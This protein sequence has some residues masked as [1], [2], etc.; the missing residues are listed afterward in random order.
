NFQ[1]M[2]WTDHLGALQQAYAELYES[3]HSLSQQR[4]AVILLT[5]GRPEMPSLTAPGA[6]AA[7]IAELRE[8]VERFARRDCPIF[9]I[10][11]TPDA[12]AADPDVQ[13]FYRNLWQEIAANTPPAAYYELHT[14]AD[15]PQVYHDIIVQLLG[16][17]PTRPIVQLQ[18]NHTLTTTIPVEAGLS[19]VVLAI[20]KHDPAI[21]IKLRRP[22][23]A[24]LRTE[25]PDVEIRGNEGQTHDEIWAITHPQAGLWVMELSGQGEVLVWKDDTPLPSATPTR[26]RLTFI[27]PPTY[28]PADQPLQIQCRILNEQD[29]YVQDIR[30]FQITVEL[31]RAGFSEALLLT[32]A[33]EEGL[34][35]ASYPGLLAGAY[36][37]HGRLLTEGQEVASLETAFEAISLPKMTVKAPTPGQVVAAGY[38]F[39]VSVTLSTGFQ[40][41]DAAALKPMGSLA[42][43]LERSP[44]DQIPV[45]LTG[46]PEGYFTGEVHVPEHEG[47]YALALHLEGT[48][49]EGLPFAE[50]QVIPLQV[51]VPEQERLPIIWL[52]AIPLVACVS[53]A[54]LLLKRRALRSPY[55]EGQWR[56][57]KAPSDLDVGRIIPLPTERKMITL[58]GQGE[59]A[60]RLP[61]VVHLDSVVALLQ[62]NRSAEG[63][64]EIWIAPAE[65]RGP[66]GLLRNE[67]PVTTS[68]RLQDGDVIAANGYS[69]RY[70]N[71]RQA[72]ARRAGTAGRKKADGTTVSG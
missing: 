42:V 40:H 39:P 43:M 63:D 16:T 68:Q 10:A 66:A 30:P 52:A 44:H 56:I 9:T 23:G 15:L 13:T 59:N 51:I 32:R 70:E 65:P 17:P 19:R 50:D 69:L 27:T 29:E 55:L 20:F 71:L 61:A 18:V 45:S 33:T 60:L 54:I 48:T 62:A 41:L 49:L 21:E 4:K 37:L 31:K 25:D 8:L 58:G 38:T 53:L 64:I 11:I 1:L 26:Y 12:A 24:L 47:A 3:E 6:K 2:D 34:Y 72:A 67:R 36:T 28:V 7:Y 14:A 57:L 5:D 46:E 22:G 35:N